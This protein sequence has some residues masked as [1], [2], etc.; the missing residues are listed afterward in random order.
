MKSAKIGD[1]ILTKEEVFDTAKRVIGTE[2]ARLFAEFVD[3]QKYFT[4]ED[5]KGVYE[6][7]AKAKKFPEELNPNI[8]N[9][10]I[11]FILLYKKGEKLNLT[12]VQNIWNYILTIKN[13]EISTLFANYFIRFHQYVRDD[14]EYSKMFTK[15][16]K[17]WFER[18]KKQLKIE[19]WD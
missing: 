4:K 1:R 19:N 9:A 14:D 5:I 15:F 3:I 13:A 6:K 7:G 17:D 10:I 16:G 11:T 12:E 8:Q 18:Y 2:V